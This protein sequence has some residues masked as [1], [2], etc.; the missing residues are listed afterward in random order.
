MK[1]VIMEATSNSQI[2]EALMLLEEAAKAKKDELWNLV[3][4]KYIHLKTALVDA[5]HAATKTISAGQ[6]RGIDALIDA[7][8]VST[9]Q[10]K[11][12]AHV[13]EDHV[14]ANPWPYVGGTAVVALLSGYILGRKN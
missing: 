10:I 7:S 1:G 6:K 5:E 8:E 4:D 11:E 3:G 14:R 9:K 13:V 2:A 12:A